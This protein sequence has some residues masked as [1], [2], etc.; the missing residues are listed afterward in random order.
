MDNEGEFL[1]GWWL[2]VVGFWFLV[3]GCGGR[4]NSRPQKHEVRLR[5]LSKLLPGNN[6]RDFGSG[7]VVSEGRGRSKQR[8]YH[9][10]VAAVSTARH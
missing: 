10:F 8:P 1:H 9:A 4:M 7:I 6:L 3:F 5:G 2:R